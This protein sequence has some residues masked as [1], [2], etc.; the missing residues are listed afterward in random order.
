MLKYSPVKLIKHFTHAITIYYIMTQF[1]DNIYVAGQTPM[2]GSSEPDADSGSG[3]KGR[4]RRGSRQRL[5]IVAIL[6]SLVVPWLL[7]CITYWSMSFSLHFSFPL[8]CYAMDLMCL[9][10]VIGTGLIAFDAVKKKKEATYNEATWAIFLFATCFLA[11][12]LGLVFGDMNFVNHM[13]PYYDLSN[14]QAHRDVD[15]SLRTG[16]QL[17]DAGSIIFSQ[18]STLN[19]TM[20]MSFKSWDTYC[21]A[22][23]VSGN[24]SKSSPSYDFWAVGVNCCSGN[25]VGGK[26]DYHC[27]EINNVHARGGLRF[28]RNDQ[29]AFFRLAVQKAEASHNIKADHPLFFIWMQD[30]HAEML[31]YMDKG[32]EYFVDG[33]FAHFVFQLFSVLV[34][35][36]AVLAAK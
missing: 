7:F 27:G 11:W 12:L 15:P 8:I 14:L 4:S 32:Y 29:R 1:A 23:I 22:P 18:G 26:A 30:P 2:Y 16:Q 24:G 31:T 10:V 17:M 33:I 20:S 9:C 6:A 28:M 35:C 13:E 5:N 19:L 3:S 36:M 34:C 25:A 21:V